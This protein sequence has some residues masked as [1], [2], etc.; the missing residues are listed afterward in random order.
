MS[1]LKLLLTGKQFDTLTK[2]IFE[3]NL[4]FLEIVHNEIDHFEETV[5]HNLKHLQ[6]LIIENN[7]NVTYLPNHLLI[8]NS[9]LNKISLHKNNIEFI[10]NGFFKTLT[11]LEFLDLSYNRI[12]KI[13]DS[14]FAIN[15]GVNILKI[16]DLSYNII[17]VIEKNSFAS[18]T[19][20]CDLKLRNNLLTGFDNK[21][22]LNNYKL[23]HLYLGYNYIHELPDELLSSLSELSML[24]LDSNSIRK[25]PPSLF[26]SNFKLTTLSLNRNRLEDVSVR[27]PQLLT[28]HLRENQ[29]EISDHVFDQIS[30]LRNLKNLNLSSNVFPATFHPNY[31]QSF[32]DL[33]VLE[34]RYVKPKNRLD[35]KF[36]TNFN[37]IN[38]NL[39]NSQFSLLRFHQFSELCNL[40][41]LNLSGN[42]LKFLTNDY[43][44]KLYNLEVLIMRHCSTLVLYKHC[45][46]NLK[47]LKYLDLSENC[48]LNISD[49]CFLNTITLENLFLSG[50]NL[51]F[52]PVNIFQNL[53]R[54]KCLHLIRLRYLVRFDDDLFVNLNNLRSLSISF[55]KISRL[56]NLLFPLNKL[57]FAFFNN[58]QIGILSKFTFKF[59]A[60][61]E[62]LNL[63]SNFITKLHKSVF[64]YLKYLKVL[65]LG[66]NCLTGLDDCIF[67]ENVKLE[68]LDLSKNNLR[69]IPDNCFKTL[70]NL[71]F[72]QFG[73]NLI[74]GSGVC[75]DVFSKNY[76]LENIDFSSTFSETIQNFYVFAN[77]KCLE[78][79]DLSF[80]KISYSSNIFSDLINLKDLKICYNLTLNEINNEI[81]RNLIELTNL[82]L[83]HNSISIL[84]WSS[85]SSLEKLVYLNLSNNYIFELRSCVFD[86]CRQL[87]YL[88]LNQNQI[89][90]I[91]SNFFDKLTRLEHLDLSHNLL[92][93]IPVQ[94]FKFNCKLRYL[95]LICNQNLN[96]LKSEH[97]SDLT[98]LQ[99]LMVNQNVKLPNDSAILNNLTICCDL[100]SV[101]HEHNS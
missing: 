2:N 14:I 62:V 10:G 91:C 41:Y 35:L 6:T 19:Q 54:L 71:K 42:K 101:L 98:N 76:R 46:A 95:S 78:C 36:S 21:L 73:F 63:Q 52:L 43:F 67:F 31:F 58:N 82:Q 66:S 90:D 57:R 87:K 25:L 22:F 27:L 13:S 61:L 49:E 39:E 56:E 44:K 9:N 69:H 15:G 30:K 26:R 79:L 47:C 32:P 93:N 68:H 7:K 64:S 24:N 50:L 40:K 88:K 48:L 84:Y 45:F 37:L 11:K 29:I 28:F 38:L 16:L 1:E 60:N 55:T 96:E 70:T 12:K 94:M 100:H 92:G 83:D 20:L 72:L 34:L 18:L 99:I 8:M 85:F 89:G 3:T 53:R 4:V 59:N 65:K 23:Q 74:G 77:L 81:F 97:F 51:G 5:F 86:K 75:N 17:E 80:C 33:E